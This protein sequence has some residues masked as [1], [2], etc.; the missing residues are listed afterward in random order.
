MCVTVPLYAD[1]IKGRLQPAAIREFYRDFYS[2]GEILSVD[3]EE[4]SFLDAARLAGTNRMEIFVRRQRGAN[5][6]LLEVRQFGQGS[7]GRGRAEYE[8][9]T[10]IGRGRFFEITGSD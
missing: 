4:R 6:A 9:R 2:G 8:Y 10:R 1:K 5:F 3:G 7:L